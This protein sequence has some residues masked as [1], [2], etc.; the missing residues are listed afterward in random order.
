MSV[1]GWI[2]LGLVSGFI[3]SHVVNWRGEG[4]ILNVVLGIVGAL[5]GGFIFTG[6]GGHGV[7]G[8]NAYSMLVAV[9]GAIVVLL[10]FHVLTGRRGLR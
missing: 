8:F 10:L 9:V 7:T 6:I 5:V 1:V 3:A 2:F 4:C